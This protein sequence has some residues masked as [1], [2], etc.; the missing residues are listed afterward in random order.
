VCSHLSKTGSLFMTKTAIFPALFV[1]RP[2]IQDHI[3]D[4]T[5]KLRVSLELIH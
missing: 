1:T 5:L 4:L 3:Y 2:K